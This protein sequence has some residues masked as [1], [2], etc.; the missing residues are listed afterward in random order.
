[1]L[2]ETKELVRKIE[3]FIERNEEEIILELAMNFGLDV[4]NKT[5]GDIHKDILNL[6]KQGKTGLDSGW[7]YVVDNS[8]IRTYRDEAVNYIFNYIQKGRIKSDYITIKNHHLINGNPI[9][10]IEFNM[11]KYPLRVQS[12]TI[13]Y[14]VNNY[15]I[16]NL[17]LN[18]AI[19]SELD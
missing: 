3:D 7:I 10:S 13:K 2:R 9:P 12:T 6:E 11:K 18:M 17:N 14:T 1:M 16:K 19:F 8:N 5:T 15:I 4:T